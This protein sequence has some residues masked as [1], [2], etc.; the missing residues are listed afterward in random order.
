MGEGKRG[1]G[2][3]SRGQTSRLQENVEEDNEWGLD[4]VMSIFWSRA[5][6]YLRGRPKWRLVIGQPCMFGQQR[7]PWT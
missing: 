6:N 2:V 1:R 3:V 5:L 4:D 7:P